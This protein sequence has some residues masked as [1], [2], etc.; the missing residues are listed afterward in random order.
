MA[1]KNALIVIINSL[2][3]Q[4]VIRKCGNSDI[5]LEKKDLAL[6]NFWCIMPNCR[7]L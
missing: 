5:S 3:N 2:K 4:C 6:R 1:I 7:I